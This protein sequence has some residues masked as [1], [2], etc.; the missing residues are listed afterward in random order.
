MLEESQQ[1]KERLEAAKDEYKKCV[2]KAAPLHEK[3][4]KARDESRKVDRAFEE[5]V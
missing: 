5:E 4:T 2:Q 3:I 1:V